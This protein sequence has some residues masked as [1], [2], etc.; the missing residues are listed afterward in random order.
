MTRILAFIASYC[1]FLWIDAKFRI[2]GSEISS[3]G[4]SDALLLVESDA[5]R[6]RFISDRRQL[7]LD[8]QP[9]QTSEPNEWFSVDLIRRLILG[10]P[11][12]SAILDESYA[13][14]VQEHLGEIEERF[15]DEQWPRTHAELRTL[16]VKRAKEMFG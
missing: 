5:L 4:G 6:L 8:M 14:F 13:V 9:A 10:R 7:L 11:E 16:K 3:S 2:V 1:G 12:K 15:A